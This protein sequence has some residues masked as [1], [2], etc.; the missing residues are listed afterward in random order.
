M[1][2]ARAFTKRI[3]PSHS[4]DSPSLL[5]RSCTVRYAPGTISRTQISL[6]TKLISTTN[7]HALNAP[8]IRKISNESSSSSIADSEPESE[9]STIDKSFLSNT[10]ASS[11]PDLSPTTPMSDDLSKKDFF[12]TRDTPSTP[13]LTAADPTPAIAAPSLPERSPT[14]SKRAHVQLA[15]QRSVQRHSPPPLAISSTAAEPHPF[16]QELAKVQEMAEEFGGPNAMVLDE[17]EQEMLSKGLQKF[18]VD[19]YLHEVM[20]MYGGVFEDQVTLNPWM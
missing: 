7:V 5:P 9:F 18:S 13:V 19:D 6:P 16:G 20:G 8:D 11:L 1:S 2:I 15:Q 10:D 17:E 3:K 14:H 12:S 4:D